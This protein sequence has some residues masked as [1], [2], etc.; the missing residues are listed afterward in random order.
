M[1]WSCVV[2]NCCCCRVPLLLLLLLLL[3]LLPLQRL[4]DHSLLLPGHHARGTSAC[5][6]DVME[7]R[8]DKLLLK[9]PLCPFEVYDVSQ[10]A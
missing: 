10:L 4:A 3:V 5:P 8:G 7:L 1:S 9:L 2:T 6:F